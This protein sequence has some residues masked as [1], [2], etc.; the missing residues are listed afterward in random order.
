MLASELLDENLEN[1][2]V[3]ERSRSKLYSVF[4]VFPTSSA[5]L[6]G[7]QLAGIQAKGSATW[8]RRVAAPE[9]T[10]LVSK[11]T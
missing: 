7:L 8:S 5:A 6:P 1:E 2:K 9:S 10:D 4:G 3:P 11:T